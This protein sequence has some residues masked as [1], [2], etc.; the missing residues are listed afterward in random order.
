MKQRER[1]RE[2]EREDFA[3]NFHAAFLWLCAMVSLLVVCVCVFVVCV[4][5]WRVVCGGDF[6]NLLCECVWLFFGAI[7]RIY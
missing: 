3:V 7:F 5:L 1:E 6:L 4:C 2:S